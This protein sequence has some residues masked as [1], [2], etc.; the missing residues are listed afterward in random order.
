M[1]HDAVEPRTRIT[2]KGFCSNG[3]LRNQTLG[4]VSP[5]HAAM[6]AIIER[7]DV[8]TEQRMKQGGKKPKW[9][10]KTERKGVSGKFEGRE[11][12]GEGFGG[13]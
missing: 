13:S 12:E 6:G 11:M 1:H 3:R 9:M 7:N 10:G 5:Q 4:A 8:R 2:S